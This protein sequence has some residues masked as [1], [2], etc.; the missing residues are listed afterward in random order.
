MV[1]HLAE[2]VYSAWGSGTVPAAVP[3]LVLTLGTWN[4][5]EKEKEREHGE[6]I[7]EVT[8]AESQRVRGERDRG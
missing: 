3:E 7:R 2:D 5:A 1:H 4:R 6:P 8:D